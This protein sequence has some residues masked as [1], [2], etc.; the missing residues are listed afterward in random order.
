MVLA[1]DGKE[2]MSEPTRLSVGIR[3]V[4]FGERVKLVEPV[5][6]RLYPG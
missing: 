5:N 1:L 4:S 2:E 3:D 6:L